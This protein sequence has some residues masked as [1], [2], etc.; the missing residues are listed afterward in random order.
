VTIPRS[1]LFVFGAALLSAPAI[2]FSPQGEQ[3]APPVSEIEVGETEITVGPPIVW[4]GLDHDNA[5]VE[6]MLAV[7]EGA[8]ERAQA[9]SAAEKALLAWQGMLLKKFDEFVKPINPAGNPREQAFTM[10]N[11][12][13]GA[14]LMGAAGLVVGGGGIGAV[15]GIGV[16]SVST[17][18]ATGVGVALFAAGTGAGIASGGATVGAT[19]IAAIMMFFEIEERYP[20][21]KYGQ[22]ATT[23][24]MGQLEAVDATWADP[25]QWVGDDLYDELAAAGEFEDDSATETR[26]AGAA[27]TRGRVGRRSR[28]AGIQESIFI[29]LVADLAAPNIDKLARYYDRTPGLSS[30]QRQQL[31]QLGAPLRK[32]FQRINYVRANRRMS[33]KSLPAMPIGTW[34]ATAWKTLSGSKGVLYN[35]ILDSVAIGRTSLTVRNNKATWSTPRA[36]RSLG[37]SS[38]YSYSIR[39]VNARVKTGIG[40]VSATVSAGSF[41]IKMGSVKMSGNRLTVGFQIAKGSRF[42][43]LSVV[44]KPKVGPSRRGSFSPKLASTLRGTLR[45]RLS[46][47]VPVIDR[48]SISGFRLSVAMPDLGPLNQLKKLFEQK[49]AKAIETMLSDI[50]GWQRIF[51]GLK[52]HTTQYLLN[53]LNGVADQY[54]FSQIQ[55]LRG[56][57]VRNGKL[58]VSVKGASWR[59]LP[60]ARADLRR[61]AQQLFRK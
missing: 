4:E 52:R 25:E 2:A 5:I 33:A 51:S 24:A 46:G 22:A 32:V 41:R 40:Q 9:G 26:T 14:G 6:E 42:G 39:P 50:P 38:S 12:F 60:R 3:A 19:V 47:S 35:L 10:L 48:I 7:V 56:L 16:T 23:R 17:G 57:V 59:G 43:R 54:G 44:A 36:F 15:A 18:T 58:Q 53:E 28:Y 27:A 13:V 30:R 31:K 21:E 45:M 11:S 55:E 37:A 49:V 34:M 29:H 20:Y 61:K 8:V 1:F